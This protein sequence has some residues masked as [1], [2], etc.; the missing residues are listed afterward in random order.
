MIVLDT[1]AWIWWSACPDRLSEKARSSIDEAEI[2]G[3]PVISCW[4]LAMLVAKGR[5]VLD[6]A[7]RL[8]V[9]QA[10]ARPRVRPLP[11]TPE[12]GIRAAELGSDFPGDPADR[13]IT[14]TA[15]AQRAVLITRDRSITAFPNVATIW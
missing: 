2:L 8:W 14:A 9:R 11:I 10:L 7:P 12:I 3:I 5:L 15:I 6:R 4:E 1:H 13:L